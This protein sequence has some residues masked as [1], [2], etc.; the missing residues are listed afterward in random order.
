MILFVQICLMLMQARCRKR[1]LNLVLVFCVY[2]VFCYTRPDSSLR[3]LRY[4]NHLLTYLLTFIFI[5]ECV[6]LLC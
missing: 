1:Q 5:D 4:I 6:R 2:F 3:Y